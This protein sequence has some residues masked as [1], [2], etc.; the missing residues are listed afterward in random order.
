MTLFCLFSDSNDFD[1]EFEFGGLQLGEVHVTMTTEP[2]EQ[3]PYPVVW[4][5]H[6]ENM[7]ADYHNNYEQRLHD[8]KFLFDKFSAD[9]FCEN[10]LQADKTGKCFLIVDDSW[11]RQFLEKKIETGKWF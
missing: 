11:G 2:T 6:S 8:N 10:H 4:L 3:K 9:T 7:S 1:D 5:R